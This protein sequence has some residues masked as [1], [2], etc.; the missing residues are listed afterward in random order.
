MRSDRRGRG[1][2]CQ[3]DGRMRSG[4]KGRRKEKWKDDRREVVVAGRVEGRSGRESR[5]KEWQEGKK[6]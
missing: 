5:C 6:E 4:R 2:E 3:E 1:K